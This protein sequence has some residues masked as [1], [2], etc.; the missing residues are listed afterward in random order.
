MTIAGEIHLGGAGGSAVGWIERAPGHGPGDG[1]GGDAQQQGG[2]VQHK[3][4]G[5]DMQHEGGD[6]QHK[7]GDAQ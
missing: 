6:A 5:G 7:G 4:G 3:G 2:D 1:V